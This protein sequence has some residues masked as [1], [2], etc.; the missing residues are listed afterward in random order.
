MTSKKLITFVCFISFV[1]AAFFSCSKF[2]GGQDN[3]KN[4]FPNDVDKKRF[5]TNKYIPI[6]FRYKI[7]DS[8]FK[9]QSQGVWMTDYIN[10]EFSF[11]ELIY[12]WNVVLKDDEGFRLY[13]QASFEDDADSPWLYAGYWGKVKIIK[14]RK[15]PVFKNGY[16]D[17]DWLILSKKANKF[18]FK[19]E[20]EGQKTLGNLPSMNAVISDNNPS[21][22]LYDKYKQ[23]IVIDKDAP[24][25]ILDIPFRKQA[26]SKGN[27]MP[28]RCQ[29]AALSSA[30]QY[31]GKKIGLEKIAVFTTDEEYNAFGLW[32]R[33]IQAGKEFG[34]SGYIDRFRN[35]DYVRKTIAENKVILCSITMPKDDVYKAP[36][37][38]SMSGHIIVLNGITNDGRV[39]VTD[40]ALSKGENPAGFRCQWLKE[41][42]EKIWMRNKGGVGMVICPIP[43]SEMKLVTDLPPFPDRT[44]K[45]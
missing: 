16:I 37:Y 3:M 6:D 12:S 30:M 25:K 28:D 33:T 17:M 10:A 40:S 22:E 9:F 43:D 29:T 15:K 27:Y 39:V 1:A 13:L 24:E 2:M 19:I 8:D 23:S 34:F 4:Q 26:D 42:F 44:K 11:D 5:S 7:N 20:S 14:E 18:R 21:L 31:L 36:P 45:E 35:W 38:P 32:P 41:D